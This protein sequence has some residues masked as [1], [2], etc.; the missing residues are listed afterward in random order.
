MEG[1][2][3]FMR[4]KLG[5]NCDDI[6]IYIMTLMTGNRVSKYKCLYTNFQKMIVS[7]AGRS[8]RADELTLRC[9][10]QGVF[11]QIPDVQIVGLTDMT[12][13]V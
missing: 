12:D 11:D 3:I 6:I 8:Q 1:I 4:H 5:G 7:P 13:R 10:V 9:R 2:W